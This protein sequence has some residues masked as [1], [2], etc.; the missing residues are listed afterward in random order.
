MR[1]LHRIFVCSTYRLS[2]GVI[3]SIYQ[4]IRALDKPSEKES[5][6]R[7]EEIEEMEE[8]GAI[9]S[10]QVAKNVPDQLLH[11]G[12]WNMGPPKDLNGAKLILDDQ[13]NH[14]DP[15]PISLVT[16]KSFRDLLFHKPVTGQTLFLTFL[17]ANRL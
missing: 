14:L 11:T 13:E 3:I 8:I 1:N 10:Y 7:M 16:L 5:N 12:L 6:N 15:F 4:C 17:T 2:L 9:L